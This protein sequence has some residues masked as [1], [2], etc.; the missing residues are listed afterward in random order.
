MTTDTNQKSRP[1]FYPAP[2]PDA[3]RLAAATPLPPYAYRPGHNPHPTQDE[4][5]HLRGELHASPGPGNIA[6]E[7]WPEIPGYLYGFDL[8]H[9]GYFWES[10]EAWEGVWQRADKRAPMGWLLQA[11][12]FNSCALIKIYERNP[13]AAAHLVNRA[14][15]R[16]AM[17]L[18]EPP[19][20]PQGRFMGLRIADLRR[21]TLE[22][23]RPL[24][25]GQFSVDAID[26]TKA[27]RI[28]PVMK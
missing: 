23:H 28:M 7:R 21:D 1:F 13:L 5:G 15:L 11:L 2:W 24:L 14:A 8:Y 10:H 17:I 27:P 25:Q 4:G 12:I 3:P 19:P 20:M 22:F 18:Q 26:L 6:P 16:L 9:N